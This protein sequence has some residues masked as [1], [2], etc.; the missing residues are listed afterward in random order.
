MSNEMMQPVRAYAPVIVSGKLRCRVC[1]R[2]LAEYEY[3]RS[4]VPEG[5]VKFTRKCR[6]CKGEE[7][8]IRIST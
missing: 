3:P 5:V 1:D 8:S 2:I 6:H 7:T 4:V